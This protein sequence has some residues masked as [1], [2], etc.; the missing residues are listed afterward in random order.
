MAL[1]LVITDAAG[2]SRRF[3]LIEPGHIFGRLDPLVVP[4]SVGATFSVPVNL[5]KYWAAKSLEFDYKL[6]AGTYF[7]E[8][9]FT[10]TDASDRNSDMEGVGLM[11]YWKGTVISNRL[12]FEVPQ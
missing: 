12:Q 11:P 2:K 7:I 9:Q 5:R 8:A 10:G 3:D 1:F 4:L 6:K